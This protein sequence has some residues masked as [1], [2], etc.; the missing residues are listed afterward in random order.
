MVCLNLCL[1]SCWV[2]LCVPCK[3]GSKAAASLQAQINQ[4]QANLAGQQVAAQ[5]TQNVAS[6]LTSWPVLLFLGAV[7]YLTRRG[8]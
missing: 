5:A 3:S 4:A 7:V 2:C 6:T 1:L 8:S